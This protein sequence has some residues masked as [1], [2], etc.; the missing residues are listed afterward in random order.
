MPSTH[1]ATRSVLVRAAPLL[2]L[3]SLAGCAAEPVRSP[4]PSAAPR[5]VQLARANLTRLRVTTEVVGTV[6]AV[7]SAS[8]APLISGTVSEVRIGLGTAVRAGDVL[9]RLSASE[10]E[11]RLEQGAPVCAFG[12]Y[13]AAREALVPDPTAPLF[14]IDLK[15]GAPGN[16][17]RDLRSHTTF[18]LLMGAL[19]ST[20]GL[21]VAALTGH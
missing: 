9:V 17:L 16:V 11:A 13:S 19:F 14:A 18:N 1:S 10:V 5:S 6:R 7:R 3:A 2:L 8:L 4:A 20:I 12:R 15:A 21:A